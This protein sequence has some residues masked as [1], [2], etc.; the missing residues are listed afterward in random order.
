M[1]PSLDALSASDLGRFLSCRHLSALDF[2][3]R[4][5]LRKTPRKYADPVLDVLIERGECASRRPDT[6]PARRL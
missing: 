2:A 3:V 4:R 6:G 1:R 5:G